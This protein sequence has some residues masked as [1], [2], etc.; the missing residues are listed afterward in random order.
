VSYQP[1]HPSDWTLELLAEEELGPAE[2]ARVA[3]HVEG[4]AHCAAEVESY[5]SLFVALSEMPSFNPSVEF[6]DSVMSRVTIV[7][8]RSPAQW[9]RR[10]LPKTQRGWMILFGLSL[11]PALPVLALLGWIV[12]HP[13]VTPGL[14]WDAAGTWLDNTGWSLLVNATGFVVESNATAWARVGVERL[15]EI[16]IEILIVG[17]LVLAVGT[18]LSAWTL[19]RTLRAPSEG[20]V[21]AH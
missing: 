7:P 20:N 18:P 1:E 2:H 15:L 8:Q 4:C 6:S 11:I 12:T 3:A 19:Y 5:R 9:L 21:Y 14:L 13:G 17:T 10:W 16:P